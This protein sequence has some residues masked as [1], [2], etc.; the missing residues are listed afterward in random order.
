LAF[1]SDERT[2]DRA[3]HRRSGAGVS[4]VDA[5]AMGPGG[6]AARSRHP[7]VFKTV[8]ARTVSQSSRKRRLGA[9]LGEYRE[10]KSYPM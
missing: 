10:S 4:G 3:Q 6:G 8:R 1:Y 5:E 9:A 7:I 2:S